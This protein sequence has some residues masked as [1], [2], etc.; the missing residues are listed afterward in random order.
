MNSFLFYESPIETEV[1]GFPVYYTD[2][3]T[4]VMTLEN[5]QYRNIEDELLNNI[6]SCYLC[7]KIPAKDIVTINKMTNYGFEY[8]ETQI[9]SKVKFIN[10]KLPDTDY[11]IRPVTSENDLDEVLNI[12]SSTFENDRISI[13]P[14]LPKC[15][16]GKR[17]SAFVINSFKSNIENVMAV[18]DNKSQNIIGFKTH[19]IENNHLITFLLGGISNEYK[20]FGLGLIS[21]ILEMNYLLNKGFLW[22]YTNISTIN[23]PVFNLE[24]G[25]LGFKVKSVYVVLRKIVNNK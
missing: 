9:Q 17:Y 12:A 19:H 3:K 13:D 6:C 18:I 2:Y 8:I 20:G 24:I 25:L 4:L 16:A 22:G 7:A 15:L 14:L 11:Y 5:D 10:R 21:D 23:I 1:F